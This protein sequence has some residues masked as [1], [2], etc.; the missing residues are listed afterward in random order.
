MKGWHWHIL[1]LGFSLFYLLSIEFQPYPLHFLFKAMPI[2]LLMLASVQFATGKTRLLLLVTLLFSSAGDILLALTF[3]NSFLFGLGAFLIAQLFYQIHFWP[4]R[5]W[6]KWKALPIAAVVIFALVIL[7]LLLPKLDKMQIPVI[8]YMLVICLMAISAIMAVN[9]QYKAMYGAIVF[10]VSDTLI[11]WNLFL[12]PV[13]YA[14]YAIMFTY[15]LAQYCL[16]CGLIAL[17]KEQNAT[18]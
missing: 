7:N 13:P 5:N 15:Y 12:Q 16:V 3:E 4:Y 9:K 14:T 17:A 8:I 2:F 1:Y 6:Q 11:A 10:L 18:T